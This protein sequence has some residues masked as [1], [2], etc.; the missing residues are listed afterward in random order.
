MRHGGGKLGATSENISGAERAR[1]WESR[2]RGKDRGGREA[3]D[4]DSG[5]E[6]TCYAGIETGETRVG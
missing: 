6:R 1:R 5:I 3:E 4:P 2:R